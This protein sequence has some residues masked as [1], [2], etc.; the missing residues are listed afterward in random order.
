MHI[1]ELDADHRQQICQGA[2]PLAPTDRRGYFNEVIALLSACHDPP[3]HGVICNII[4][5]AQGK[6]KRAAIRV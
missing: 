6:F 3:S 5:L 1:N 2:V 4:R